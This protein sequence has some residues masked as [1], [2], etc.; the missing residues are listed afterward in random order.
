MV[1]GIAGGDDFCVPL[2]AGGWCRASTGHPALT[3][4]EPL[5]I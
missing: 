2:M 5:F 1:Q 4:D 3:D